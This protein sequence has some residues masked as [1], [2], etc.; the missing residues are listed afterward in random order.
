MVTTIR[1]SQSP[2]G[3]NVVRMGHGSLVNSSG[4]SSVAGNAARCGVGDKR[5]KEVV[6]CGA[7]DMA[8]QNHSAL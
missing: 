3:S 1:K 8:N 6:L 7:G 5:T 4:I 2:A